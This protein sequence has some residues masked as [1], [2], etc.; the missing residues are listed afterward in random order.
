MTTDVI[1][2]TLA[3]NPTWLCYF[4]T[5]THNGQR[6]SPGI[7][8]VLESTKVDDSSSERLWH[9]KFHRRS[10]CTARATWVIV[11]VQPDPYYQRDPR[12]H[13][14][15]DK[16]LDAAWK[17]LA[18]AN[19][20]AFYTSIVSVYKLVNGERRSDNRLSDLFTRQMRACFAVRERDYMIKLLGVPEKYLPEQLC[21]F[22]SRL[23]KASTYC[24]EHSGDSI[25]K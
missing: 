14:V 15:C 13:Y 24:I 22:R 8:A 23:I 10:F 7:T 1:A 4:Y 9:E 17:T 18:N 19:D 12:V 20:C 2:P 5:S 21:A 25:S 16:H 3:R 6:G 11:I